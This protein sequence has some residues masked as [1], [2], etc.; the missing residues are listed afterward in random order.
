[1][2]FSLADIR[3]PLISIRIFQRSEILF[4]SREKGF[5]QHLIQDGYP[6]A[7][8]LTFQQITTLL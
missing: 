2:K 5:R 7:L 1:M 8:L 6:L 4:I 3:P